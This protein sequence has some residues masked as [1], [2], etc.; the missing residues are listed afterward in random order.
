MTNPQQQFIADLY[1]AARRISEETGQ[2]WELILAQ[3]ATETG[4]GQKVLPGTNNL[5]NIKADSSWHGETKTF[6]VKEYDKAGNAHMSEEKFRVYGSYEESLRDRMAFLETN[7]RYAKAGIYDPG[8]KGNLEKEAH[9]LQKAGYATN[10]VYA[11]DMI[12]LARGPTMAAGIALAEGRGPQ[13]ASHGGVLHNG[14]RGASVTELQTSLRDLGYKDAS[15]NELRPDGHFGGNT[16][17]AL[18]TFQRE[19][20]LQDDGVAG[21]RTMS[22]LNEA[23]A[24]TISPSE[25]P[26][27]LTL[28][29]PAHQAYAMY[30]QARTEIHKLDQQ[31][32]RI[33]TVQSDQLA[34]SL[35]ASAVASN[36]SRIDYVALSDDASRIYGVQGAVSSPF[37][38]VAEADVMQ[39]LQTPMSQSSQV[40]NEHLSQAASVQA[41]QQQVDAAAQTQV[42]QQLS[43]PS[44]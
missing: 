27:Y 31:H 15:G 42:Q 33:P 32:G 4:W 2:S 26:A 11:S 24:R 28:D 3:A 30:D 43:G 36:M 40:A 41:V 7:P 12:E 16:E 9:A 35:T 20:G 44:L 21:P 10:P 1:P 13:A 29:D 18:K 14:A 19:H 37:K 23:Q 6:N 22:A 8:V 34:G 17:H 5:Y 39:G 25:R 38:M